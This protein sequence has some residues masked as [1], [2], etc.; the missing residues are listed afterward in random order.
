MLP[1]FCEK[2]HFFWLSG[3]AAENPHRGDAETQ[4]AKECALPPA[5]VLKTSTKV[6]FLALFMRPTL[7]PY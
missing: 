2:P 6:Q 4:A 7:R 1:T 5:L 3:F